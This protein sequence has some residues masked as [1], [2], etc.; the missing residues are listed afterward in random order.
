MF[1]LAGNLARWMKKKKEKNLTIL[2][3]GL[4]NAG[5]STLLF[6]LKDQLPDTVTPTIGF[7]PS[8]VVRGK[9]TIQ[10][11][12]VG[13]AKNFR[14]VWQSYYPE[15]HGVIY[16]VDAADRERFE[17]S[18]ETLDKT[19]ESEGIVGK[20]VLIFA[21]KQDLDGCASAPELTK[22]LGLLERKDC[23]YQ[24]TACTAK[25]AEGQG[26]DERIGKALNWLLDSIDKD[27]NT[28][29]NRVV[30]EKAERDRKEEEVKAARRKRAEE[31]KALRL[32]EQAEAEAERLKK[33]QEEKNAAGAGEESR[34]DAHAPSGEAWAGA[35][36]G[37]AGG[38]VR[39]PA[40]VGTGTPRDDG[41]QNVESTPVR[42][43]ASLGGASHETPGKEEAPL[44][45]SNKLPALEVSS[46]LAD[47]GSPGFGSK[48]KLGNL[49]PM[50]P[51]VAQPD[52]DLT[53][54][55]AMPSPVP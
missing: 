10:W 21:N 37:D 49:K 45:P 30:T 4:D 34:G 39:E 51:P 17:E 42:N 7:R 20:P 36:K 32:K 1:T 28:L 46:S 43:S 16:V 27:Y 3:L 33:E 12:D 50:P 44:K 13:G 38:S 25:P 2:L 23:S 22:E 35:S 19:L 9:Y 5:K 47:A 29:N 48:P 54:P 24:M 15:V 41:V 14:R 52:P 6:G 31:S 40:E 11:F 8:T 26:V 18:K 55:N 53:L